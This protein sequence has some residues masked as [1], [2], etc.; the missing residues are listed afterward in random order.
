MVD[1]MKTVES[2]GAPLAICINDCEIDHGQP[3]D[4]LEEVCFRLHCAFAEMRWGNDVGRS[5]RLPFYAAPRFYQIE[6]R[7]ERG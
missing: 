5:S 7:N 1:R 4:E 3:Y 2:F 6:P